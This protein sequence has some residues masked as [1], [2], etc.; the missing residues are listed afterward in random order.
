MTLRGVTCSYWRLWGNSLETSAQD[1]CW[2]WFRK[3]VF[4]VV[5]WVCKYS[6]S[7]DEWRWAAAPCT[8]RPG[9]LG[10]EGCF[11]GS[12]AELFYTLTSNHCSPMSAA[13]WGCEGS[14]KA[15]FLKLNPPYFLPC[16]LQDSAVRGWSA[17]RKGVL[18]RK[19]VQGKQKWSIRVSV[20]PLVQ[21]WQEQP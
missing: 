13:A 1:F 7:R 20:T 6:H 15:D 21:C 12:T 10:C 18:S 2:L 8:T 16:L 3:G 11:L 19:G 9:T 14:Q 17:C 4:L 5:K